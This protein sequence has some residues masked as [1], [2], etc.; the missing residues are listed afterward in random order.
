MTMCF[1]TLWRLVAKSL[2]CWHMGQVGVNLSKQC[3]CP[4]LTC[5]SACWGPLS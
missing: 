5:Q 2:V 4:E 1:W 3:P